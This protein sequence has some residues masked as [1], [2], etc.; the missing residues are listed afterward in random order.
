MLAVVLSVFP[1]PVQCL[2]DAS[3]RQDSKDDKKPVKLTSTD[4]KSLH[5]RSS[6][7]PAWGP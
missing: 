3:I 2:Q 1:P 6:S 5:T 7:K 4:E